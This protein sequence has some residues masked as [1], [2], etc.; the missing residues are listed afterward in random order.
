MKC[1]ECKYFDNTIPV[2]TERGNDRTKNAEEY[3][4]MCNNI[5]RPKMMND[6]CGLFEE[7]ED[8][9][10]EV[11]SVNFEE[12]VKNLYIKCNGCSNFIVEENRA[13]EEC[14]VKCTKYN[15]EHKVPL[16]EI[17]GLREV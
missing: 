3:I 2:S 10:E 13:F 4:G 17:V 15:K 9:K 14:R 11:C 12:S 1:K 6:K 7:K 8:R 16:R 5:N